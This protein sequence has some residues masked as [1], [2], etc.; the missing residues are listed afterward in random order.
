MDK[1]KIIRI[2]IYVV[3]AIVAI[4][5]L[6]RVGRKI[7]DKIV[8][9]KKGRELEGSI[10]YS[11]LTYDLPQYNSFA[12]QLYNAMKGGGTTWEVVGEV[13]GKMET[14]SDVLMLKKAYGVKDGEDLEEWIAGETYWPFTGKKEE[15]INKI[16]AAKSINYTF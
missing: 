1:K 11:K 14:R 15:Y 10:D 2:S 6:W 7:A 13:F 3:V 16:L 8:S 12:T 9:N 5:I 4:W